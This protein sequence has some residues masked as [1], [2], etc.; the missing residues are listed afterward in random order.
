MQFARFRLD[1][2]AA[3]KEAFEFGGTVQD[4]HTKWIALEQAR[5]VSTVEEFHMLI[6]DACKANI[7]TVAEIRG[8]EMAKRGLRGTDRIHALQCIISDLSY[9]YIDLT[10]Y[11]RRSDQLNT[12]GERFRLTERQLMCKRQAAANLDSMLSTECKTI[13][14]ANEKVVKDVKAKAEDLAEC[15][16]GNDPAQLRDGLLAELSAR[17]VSLEHLMVPGVNLKGCM[18]RE[19]SGRRRKKMLVRLLRG[20]DG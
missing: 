6:K 9:L 16:A 4:V 20:K 13:F 11:A 10:V 5:C 12:V 7:S 18:D 14:R 17:F 1:A 19:K 3:I 8:T 2:E 15:G